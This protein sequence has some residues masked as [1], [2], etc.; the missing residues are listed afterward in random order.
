MTLSN[1]NFKDEDLHNSIVYSF[2]KVGIGKWRKQELPILVVNPL[3][4]PKDWPVYKQ[5][6][7]NKGDKV[8]THTVYIMVSEMLA[9]LVVKLLQESY[10]IANL[11]LYLPC[12]LA[13]QET[14]RPRILVWVW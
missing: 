11:A 4:L 3:N 5:W 8:R 14:P 10:S 1:L 9:L 2:G 7:R 12:L 13:E 6:T